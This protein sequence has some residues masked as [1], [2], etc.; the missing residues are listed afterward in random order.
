MPPDITIPRFS[1]TEI[2]NHFLIQ[3]IERPELFIRV[4]LWDYTGTITPAFR[5]Y[6]YDLLTLMN[7]K[8]AV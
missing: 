7:A 1:I 8:Q 3:D 6:A 5:E 4:D 2:G